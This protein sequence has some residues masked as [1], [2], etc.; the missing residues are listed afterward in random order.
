MDGWFYIEFDGEV[1]VR[2]VEVYGGKY[3]SSREA[4]HEGLGGGLCDQ[5]L[6]ELDFGSEDEISAEEFE[7]VWIESGQISPRPPRRESAA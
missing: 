1:P 4:Y 7:K 2:Q 6:S 5:H 3:F